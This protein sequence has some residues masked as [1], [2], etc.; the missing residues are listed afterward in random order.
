MHMF[1]HENITQDFD[2]VFFPHR[3]KFID[4]V[5]HPTGGF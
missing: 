4:N 5:P 3:A 2:V 1:R